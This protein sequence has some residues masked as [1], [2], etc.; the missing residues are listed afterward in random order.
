ML[1]YL[2][3]A[4]A[5]WLIS[6]VL[7]DVF[8]R[9]E[10]YHGYN[11]F[12][13]LFTFLLGALLPLW[14]WQGD[15][16]VYTAA[17]QRPVERVIAAKETI[18]AS[19]TP[20]SASVDWELYL[21]Y[22]YLAGAF[23]SLVLLLAEVVKIV[24]L[25]RAGN[26]YREGSCI[27]I[28]TNKDCAPFSIFNYVFVSSRA[29]YDEEEWATIIAH[30]QMHGLLFH[31]V[32]LLLMQV[33]RIVFWFHPLVYVYQKRLMMQHEYQAD[34]AGQAQPQF[35]GRFLIEQALLQTAPKITHSFNRSPIKNRIVMLTRKSST[36]ARIKMLVF[37][38]LALVCALCFSKNAFSQ[39]F[40]KNGNV[41]TYRGNRFE[42]SEPMTDTMTMTD[43][44]SG[45]EKQMLVTRDP[46]VIKMNGKKLYNTDEVTTR[47]QPF[48]KNGSIEEYLL[49]NLSEELNKLP[50][51]EYSPGLS[52][53]VFDANGKIIFYQYSG[54]FNKPLQQDIEKALANKI[55]KLL[56]DAP[57]VQ[58]AKLN[59]QNVAVRSDIMLN[60][61][62][63]EVKNHKATFKKR[64][65][66]S[67]PFR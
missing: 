43:P 54:M 45:K 61:Y 55:D 34:K 25:Y 27:I 49:K 7:F 44:V 5:I 24:G 30:E 53:V 33:A 60:E 46:L 41:I 18:V 63:V 38:P 17:L 4:T 20:V 1:Q 31:F 28:E 59:S 6:L 19:A 48:T 23:V 51:G 64:E 9:R 50:D 2:L 29:R 65:F 13:L 56:H 62:T 57:A 15:S 66:R 22:I 58:P 36:T 21:G 10:S 42:M 67:S 12:Y 52:E 16:P 32:D 26:R 47:P 35:Y 37:V 39:K 40:V 3:N 8:L 11:R 14:Q